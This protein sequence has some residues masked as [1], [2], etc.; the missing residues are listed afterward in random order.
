[1]GPCSWTM[2]WRR[3]ELLVKL[4]A[5]GD[6]G[7]RVDGVGHGVGGFGRAGASRESE[8][9]REEE[10][11]RGRGVLGFE[12]EG[13]LLSSRGTGG[14]LPRGHRHHGRAPG[15]HGGF[16]EQRKMEMGGGLGRHT[17]HSWPMCTVGCLVFLFI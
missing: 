11:G 10:G 7:G 15:V 4:Q 14:W 17:V 8:A 12:G 5:R 1:M 3:T 13:G 9:R 2:Q 6:D 16:C